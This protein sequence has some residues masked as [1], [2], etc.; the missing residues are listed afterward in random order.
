MKHIFCQL[1]F[2]VD[3]RAAVQNH[4]LQHCEKYTSFNCVQPKICGYLNFQ[5]NRIRTKVIARVLFIFCKKNLYIA[6]T[7]LFLTKVMH[8]SKLM[9]CF[10]YVMYNKYCIFQSRSINNTKTKV[11]WILY[12]V[13]APFNRTFFII[14]CNNRWIK[15]DWFSWRH[16][17][18]HRYN[19]KSRLNSN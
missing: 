6:D 17:S 3:R 1:A 18:H 10:N 12:F 4:T 14:A 9:G 15:I 13:T 7:P 11:L 8:Y 16:L 2:T 19:Q 5:Q